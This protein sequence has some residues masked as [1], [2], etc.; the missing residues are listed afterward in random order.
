MKNV[1][2]IL[3][4]GGMLTLTACQQKP[5]TEEVSVDSTT[6]MSADTVSMTADS[7]DTGAGMS[8][9]GVSTTAPVESMTK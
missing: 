1:V 3:F 7:L 5:K 8:S 6:T 9:E 2:A 4:V